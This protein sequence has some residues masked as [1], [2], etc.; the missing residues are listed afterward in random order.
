[1]TKEF[2]VVVL[3]ELNVDIIL[4]RIEK[5]PEIGKEILADE[6]VVTLGS[7]SAIFAS[8]LST[9]GARVAFI[10]KVGDDGFAKV[11]KNSLRLKH[12]DTEQILTSSS[13]KTGAT[14]VLNY[15]EDRA[16]ITYPGAMNDLTIDDIDFDFI[17]KAKHLHFSSV[18]MQPG[19]KKSIAEIFKKA[20]SL[21]LTTSIDP[22]WDPNETWDFDIEHTMPF[23]DVFLPNKIEL[24]SIT[25]ENT[26][27]S[28]VKRLHPAPKYLIVKNGNEGSL[29]Y[30]GKS[31]IK[32]E[33]FLNNQ[34]VDCI[35]AG[36]SF[37]AGFIK[38]F[39]DGKSIKEC[40]T[41]GSVIGAVSTT[42]AGGTGAFQNLRH[43]ATIAN[44]YF[45]YKI[46]L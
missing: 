6:M 27:E 29:C 42:G 23:L 33:A 32:Q 44:E 11:V 25:K 34:V 36:D 16:N 9:L 26:I 35:G 12:V 24:L 22:Q 14:I 2:D 41:Y 28:A 20:K 40:L 10:G 31:L 7:S 15:D 45:Q 37:N 1:M 43:I 8:N 18:F 4:N 21:G 38:Q 46:Q 3:G 17:A 19:I 13:F 5:F 30:D 39:V